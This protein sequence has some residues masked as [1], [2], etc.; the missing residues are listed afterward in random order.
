MITRKEHTLDLPI[1]EE[2]IM[3]Y[4]G[5]ALIQDAFPNLAPELREFYKTGV[6]PEEW[7]EMYGGM[8]DEEEEEEEEE[9]SVKAIE[10]AINDIEDNPLTELQ[11]S[12][13]GYLRA[14]IV[15]VAEALF[16]EGF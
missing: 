10:S 9:D 13:M 4:E 11:Q 2:E 6:T 14:N 12:L 5:G 7:N 8:D 1:T 15:D 16:D 3:K